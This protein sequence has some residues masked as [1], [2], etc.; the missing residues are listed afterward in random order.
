MP[1][2]QPEGHA[3]GRFPTTQWSRL[4]TAASRDAPEAREALS[5][6]C[7]AY[8]YPIYAYVRHRGYLTVVPGKKQ[9]I[10]SIELVKG[11]DRSAPIVLAAT[12]EGFE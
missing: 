12:V 5:G 10:A 9:T 2:L 8:W 3:P 6:L 11:S 1:Q 4:V 7:E